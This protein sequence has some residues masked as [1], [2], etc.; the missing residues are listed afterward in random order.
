MSTQPSAP[1]AAA[2]SAT[3]QGPARP[4]PTGA[5]ATSPID[6][7]VIKSYGL[8][9]S[10][11]IGKDQRYPRRAQLLG[12][13]GTTEVLVRMGVDAK[14]KDVTVAKSSGHEVLDEEAL[15]KVRRAKH[16]PPPPEGFKGRE[17]T[18]LVPIVFK[19]E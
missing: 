12:W 10:K 16:L 18:V 9:L 17:F 13:Q 15:E 11:E 5:P 7:G 2:P 1:H 14:V 19:L 6:Q 3:K 4:A 8:L